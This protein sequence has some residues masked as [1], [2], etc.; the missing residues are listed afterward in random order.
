MDKKRVINEAVK[1]KISDFARLL[2]QSGVAANQIILY[3]SYAKGT[4]REGS[5]IDLCVIS[6]LF[7][8]NPDYY[9]KKIWHLAAKIDSA[10]TPISFTPADLND[11]YSTLVNEINQH[12]IRVV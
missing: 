1:N 6:P 10:I 3:G 5:D 2:A 9:F 11:K 7:G 8:K 12:G 4:A